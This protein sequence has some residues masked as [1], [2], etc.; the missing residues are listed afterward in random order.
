[1][2][3]GAHELEEVAESVEVLQ[4]AGV[5]D[6]V[7]LQCVAAYPTP[8]SDINVRVVSTL[9]EEFDVLAGLSDHTL[10]PVTAPSAAVALGASMVEKHFTL[11]RSMEGPDHQ[12]ALE[13]DELEIMVD[14]VRDTE[15]VLGDTSKKVLDIEEELHNL[16]R[17]RI[18]ATKQIDAGEQLTQD[19]VG[20]LRSGN[21]STGLHPRYYE[22]VLGSI[23]TTEISSDAGI[24]WDDI[25][26]KQPE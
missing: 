10:D 20:V 12:F 14:A 2:S 18:H 23:A 6:L 19:N 7:L 26:A 21:Q 13:P 17:R 15:S 4:E 5:S 25:D 16:A 3:T 11:D 9:Q 8:L 22:N 1:M 24:T